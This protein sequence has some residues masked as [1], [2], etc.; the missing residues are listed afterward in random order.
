MFGFGD[1][2]LV[3]ATCDYADRSEILR[4]RYRKMS[5]DYLQG[6]IDQ[7]D[8]SDG[9]H[10]FPW[11]GQLFEPQEVRVIRSVLEEMLEE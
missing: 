11:I 5:R 9:I 7:Y 6:R 1:N 8:N 10:H 3:Y 2:R 4:N